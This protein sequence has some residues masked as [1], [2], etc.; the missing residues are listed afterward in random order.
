MRFFTDEAELLNLF[1]NPTYHSVVYNICQVLCA[2]PENS[3]G[4]ALV[5]W[6]V[7]KYADRNFIVFLI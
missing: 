1:K 3:F 2:H 7:L 6:R 4:I 5:V